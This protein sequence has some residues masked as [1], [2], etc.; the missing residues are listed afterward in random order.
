MGR[1]ETCEEPTYIFSR[2][3]V[4]AVVECRSMRAEAKRLVKLPCTCVK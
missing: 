4:V 2:F 3:V 1:S